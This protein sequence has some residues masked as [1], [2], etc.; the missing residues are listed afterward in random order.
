MPVI[1]RLDGQVDDVLI[2]P[3]SK[4]QRDE[5]SSANADGPSDET[6]GSQRESPAPAA[7][8]APINTPPEGES[9]AR[10]DE[11]PVWLL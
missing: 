5:H 11:L 7:R 10:A 6:T 3:I 2:S 4:R 8:L 9:S 1:G